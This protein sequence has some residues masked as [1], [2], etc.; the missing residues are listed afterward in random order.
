VTHTIL[1]A[2]T[3]FSIGESIL[4]IEE[5]VKTAQTLGAKA[6]GITDTMSVTALIDFTSRCKKAELKPVI[7]CR[8]RI[9]DDPSWRK[10][11]T[12]AGQP[13]VKNPP[14]YYMNWYVLS[15]KSLQ[16]LFR[17]LTLGN[18][19]SH[20]YYTAKIGIG[21]LLAALEE[22]TAEDV[23][24]TTGDAYSIIHHP[25]VESILR[26]IDTLVPGALHFNLTPLN[27]PY[28]DT[29]NKK[30]IELQSAFSDSRFLVTRPALYPQDGAEALD[31]MNAISKNTR[32]TELWANFPAARDVHPLPLQPF[33][34]EVGHAIRRLQRRGVANAKE[35]FVAGVKA[36]SGLVEKVS[37]VWSKKPVSLPKMAE[38]EFAGLVDLCKKG[39]A[40]RFA[41]P[42]FNHKPSTEELKDVYQP[43]LKYE[44]GVLK[45]LGFAGYFLLVNDVV[46]HAKTS[47]ILV[48]PGRGSV[49]GSLVAYLLGIT[50]CDPIRFGLLFERFINPSRLDLPDADLDFMSERRDEIIKYLVTRYGE[51]RVACITNFSTLGPASA[52]REVGKAF[53][54]A[55]PDYRCSKLAPK[56]HGIPVPLVEA[57]EEVPE[58]AQFAKKNALIW[59]NCLKLE[60][61][62]R[63]LGQHAAGVV[64][65]GVDLTERAVIERRADQVVCWDKRTVEDQGLVKMDILGLQTL[66]Q[67][68]LTLKY[69]R[70]RH[71]KKV[72]LLRIP[73]DDPKVL[74]NFAKGLAIGIFQFESGGM[75]RLL[76]ELGADGTITFDD[77]TAATAL[78]RPGPMDSGMMESYFMRKQGREVIEYDHPLMEPALKETYGVMVYQEQVM[79]VARDIA[80]YSMADADKLRKIMGKK[81]PEEMAKER[82]QFVDGCLAHVGMHPDLAGELF[83]KI[84]KFA[85]YGFNKSHATTYTLISYQNMWLKTYY[86][87]EFFAAAL[88][89]MKDDRLPALLKDAERFGIEV[90][91]PD[92][93]LSTD[94]FE[95]Y[96]DTKLVIPFNR[97]KGI[98]AKTT[99]AILAARKLGKFTSKEDFE[100]RVEKRSCNV[101]HRDTL[102]KVGAFASIDP[103]S[104]PAKDPRRLADQRELIP[105]LIV[106]NVP[107]NRELATDKFSKAKI[108]E[109][110]RDYRAKHGPE[111]DG[112]G[113][114][115]KIKF[116][117]NARFMVISD[118]PTHEEEQLGMTWGTMFN[119][120]NA[121]LEANELHRNDGY[122]TALIKR[123]KEGKQ[124]SPKE[125]ETYLPY[126]MQEIEVLKPPVIVLLG[127]TTVRQFIPDFKGKASEA[128]G[129]VTYSKQ[130]DA[131]L[132]VGFSPGE[133]WHSAEK[134]DDMNAVFA[135]VASLLD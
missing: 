135:S 63:S 44:L 89:L 91:M 117:S 29:L 58:I 59:E 42:V 66:D 102:D 62:M 116:G 108:V 73:L 8:L 68:A 77:I 122:W 53:N 1:A 11:K 21:D 14:E 32:L 35:A 18:S 101:R 5:L 112:D 119:Y 17:L 25:N 55:E 107:V 121:A 27:T 28:W 39:W 36:T 7:G 9:V 51:K 85:G 109:I 75:R 71:S 127:S 83:D 113:W 61:V 79:Q 15:E 16:H 67:I 88:S 103:G 34:G 23:A 20:F 84:E 24:L 86:P 45:T 13:K 31:I 57:A 37:Y 60:G 50:D 82:K 93:N 123:C 104:L 114:P 80:G 100:T 106:A 12:V 132:V 54:L 41:D 120:V 96:T 72:D 133:I 22:L 87:V 94:R 10:P 95:I 46:A 38:D 49:G 19:E 74:D 52:I 92:A 99:N 70:S 40:R 134:Q 81:L 4:S 76:K 124:V 129:Q 47:G 126:L 118:A 130:Y 64:V 131:N 97:V 56:K 98:A 90:M 6:V 78:Y 115:V 43:R 110:M 48:G 105:G 3:D 65:G 33:V 30:T 26:D 125:V 69:I 2:R 111:G 128:A